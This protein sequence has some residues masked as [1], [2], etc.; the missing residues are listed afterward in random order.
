VVVLVHFV[1]KNLCGMKRKKMKVICFN[2]QTYSLQVSSFLLDSLCC[3]SP[4][5]C[6]FFFI[7]YTHFSNSLANRN[8]ELSLSILMT[9]K[10]TTIFNNKL[11]FLISYSISINKVSSWPN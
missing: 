11:Q 7:L 9:L 5:S 1:L 2:L 8:T 6:L 10:L 4:I 3:Y